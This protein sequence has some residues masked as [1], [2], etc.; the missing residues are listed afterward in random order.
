MC[1]CVIFCIFSLIN[2]IIALGWYS[3]KRYDGKRVFNHHAYEAIFAAI[4]SFVLAA[5]YTV[6]CFFVF[7]I[8]RI[9]P[10]NGELNV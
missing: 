7:R 1:F 2:I 4:A 9:T 6:Y 8:W 10:T 3:E 5:L